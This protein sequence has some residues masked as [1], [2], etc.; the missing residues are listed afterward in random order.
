MA[1]K[2]ETHSRRRPDPRQRHSGNAIVACDYSQIEVRILAHVTDDP[3]LKEAFFAEADI[4]KATARAAFGKADPTDDER[5]AAKTLTFGILYGMGAG[6][7]ARRLGISRPEAIDFQERFFDA[8]PTVR[9]WIEETHNEV[10]SKGYIETLFGRRLYIPHCRSKDSG[11][12]ARA[13]RQSVNYKIQGSAA[14][15]MRLAITA[16]DHELTPTS[17]FMRQARS[18]EEFTSK[19]KVE[20]RKIYGDL[21]LSVHDELVLECPRSEAE[22]TASE[23]KRI[24][25]ECSSDWVDWRVPIRADASWGRTWREAKEKK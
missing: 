17:Q 9:D 16:V 21:L 6:S 7:L 2:S 8:M 22:R 13:H 15:L 14:D 19:I 20:L 12:R 11:L 24:M 18:A 1:A 23:V 3:T 25:E 4:H 10:T 5:S